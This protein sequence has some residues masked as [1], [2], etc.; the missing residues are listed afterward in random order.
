MMPP[1]EEP[2]M[3][4]RGDRLSRRQFVVGTAGLGLLAGC[5]RWPGQGELGPKVARVGWL[6]PLS[7]P[8]EPSPNEVALLEGLREYSWVEGKNLTIARR[9]ADNQPARLPDL[10]TE[11]A[12]LN[13]DVIVTT[14]TPAAQAVKNATSTVPIVM[15]NSGDPVGARLVASLAHPGGNVTGLSEV[16]SQLSEKRL[17]LLKGT[18][19]QVSRVGA[20]WNPT[21]PASV[22][23]FEKTRAAAQVLG[24]QLQSLEVRAPDDLELALGA[25]IRER[26][27]AVV[28]VGDPFFNSSH[29]REIVDFT[30]KH[31]LPTMYFRRDQVVAGG[32]MTYGVS[33]A[34]LFRRTAYYVDRILKGAK[35][36]DLPV[37]QPMTFEFVVNLKTAAALGITF[38]NEILLQVT[39]VIQ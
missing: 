31:A 9:Y 13:P 12:Q 19:P 34:G 10:A 1:R 26:A 27:D 8:P 23:A 17:E 18:V 14:G 21:N 28:I 38:P 2:P 24:A 36:G 11:L 20:L 6:S 35:P 7:A 15:T 22:L 39:E 25:A 33:F 3:E 29:I 37:E 5:G 16:S 4:H 30:A 32:L